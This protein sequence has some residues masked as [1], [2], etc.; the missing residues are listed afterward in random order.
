[1]AKPRKSLIK[2]RS[3]A[4]TRQ[5]GRCF[6]CNQPMSTGNIL[7]FANKHKIT[8][9]QAK[10][11]QCTGEHLKAHHEGGS[12]KPNNIVAACWFCN[13]KRHRLKNP[14][15]PEQY[16]DLIQNRMSQG[17]WHGIRLS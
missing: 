8:P 10:L 13:Q 6:Y 17:G 5:N 4:F 7:E 12:A 14:P 11:L 15:E 16:K 9:K 3:I 2:P 1:M